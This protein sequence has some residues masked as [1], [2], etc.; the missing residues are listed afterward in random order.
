MNEY[1][2]AIIRQRQLEDRSSLVNRADLLSQLL[3]HNE[4]GSTY[5]DE[6]LRDFVMNFLIAGRDTTAMLLTWTFY[7]LA[8]HPEIE[9]KVVE[10]MNQVM[11]DEQ[12][13]WDNIKQLRYL[14]NVLQETLRLFPPVPVDGYTAYS[15]DVL[16]GG[17]SI[18]KGT[19]VYYCSYVLHRDPTLFP[20]PEEFLPERWDNPPKHPCA[21]IP[22]HSGARTCLGKE[23]AFEEARIMVVN[24]LRKF[25]L[26][27]VDGF[28]PRIKQAIILTSANGM[29]MR[30]VPAQ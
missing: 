16:P 5:T 26:R 20:N 22:F 7:L 30:L 10:E 23:M 28:E 12:P 8:K 17:Y 19:E 15:D 27:L 29:R 11:K 13:T 1:T 14:K 4:E 3:T 9:A 2:F 25:R 18:T 24:L 6:E 21:Y